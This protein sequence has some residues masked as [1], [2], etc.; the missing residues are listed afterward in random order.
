MY[1]QIFE[2]QTNK[3][4]TQIPVILNGLNYPT[5]EQD[6]FNE[7]WKAAVE[8]NIV[9]QNRRDKYWFKLVRP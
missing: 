8:D 3:L 1:V 5:S 9:I 6:Y 2:T 7:T 4:V